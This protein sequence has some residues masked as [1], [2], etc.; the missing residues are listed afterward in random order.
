MERTNPPIL[1]DQTRD[2]LEGAVIEEEKYRII[3]DLSRCLEENDDIRTMSSNSV[4]VPP[5]SGT[6]VLID[7]P[8]DAKSAAETVTKVQAELQ[9]DSSQANPLSDEEIRGQTERQE[10]VFTSIGSIIAHVND[11]FTSNYNVH[12][13]FNASTSLL[14][15]YSESASKLGAIKR[16]LIEN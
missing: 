12:A 11:I 2:Y 1:L 7:S 16:A 13:T 3:V 4:D 9:D 15:I 10:K 14:E 5:V 6:T 8:D